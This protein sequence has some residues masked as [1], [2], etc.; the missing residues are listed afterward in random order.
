VPRGQSLAARR[1]FAFGAA[2]ARRMR[3]MF[4]AYQVVILVGLTGSIVV[5][6][7]GH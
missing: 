2:N 7:A 4:I 1:R 6:L 5:G 3:T